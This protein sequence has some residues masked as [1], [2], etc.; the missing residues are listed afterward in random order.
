M[1]IDKREE[2]GKAGKKPWL[3]NKSERQVLAVA[4]SYTPIA[5]TVWAGLDVPTTMEGAVESLASAGAVR[6][7]RAIWDFSADGGAVGSIPLETLLPDNAVIKSVLVDV[8]TAV[9]SAG[10]LTL[11]IAAGSQGNVLASSIALAS[12]GVGTSFPAVAALKTTASREL[13]LVIGTA[14][15][16]AGRIHFVVEYIVTE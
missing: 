8:L 5:A 1:T 9:A 2:I 4:D 7:V 10:A 13:N 3:L 16:T 15:A 12:L 11:N 6:A 14:A